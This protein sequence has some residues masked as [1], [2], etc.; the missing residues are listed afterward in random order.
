MAGYTKTKTRRT[1]GDLDISPEEFSQKYEG[2]EEPEASEESPRAMHVKIMIGA[3]KDLAGK[4]KSPA[5]P[6]LSADKYKPEMPEEG[7]KMDKFF[8]GSRKAFK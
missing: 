8:K 3:A 7:T 2:P 1:A 4:A 5:K 6:G